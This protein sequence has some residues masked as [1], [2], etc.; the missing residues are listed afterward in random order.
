M[1]LN[2]K[3]LEHVQVTHAALDQA[4][5]ELTKVAADKQAAAELIPQ[6]VEALIKFDRIDPKDREKAAQALQDPAQALKILLKTADTSVTVNPAPASLGN[7]Q[8]NGQTK[9]ANYYL[10]QK[11]P[12]ERDSDRAFREALMK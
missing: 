3:V 5:K 7:P 1:N 2:E 10:G 9:Q 4:S 11:S 8:G 12:V 6:V